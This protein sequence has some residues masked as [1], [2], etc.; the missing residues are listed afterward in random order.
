MI[1]KCKHMYVYTAGQSRDPWEEI[2]L[3]A[4]PEEIGG[5]VDPEYYGFEKPWLNFRRKTFVITEGR[6]ILCYCDTQGQADEMQIIL[7]RA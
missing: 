7:E 6:D 2:Y 1:T 5:L 4:E 3:P